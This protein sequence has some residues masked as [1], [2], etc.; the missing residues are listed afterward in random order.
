LEQLER[1]LPHR[2]G[3]VD[4]MRVAMRLRRKWKTLRPMQIFV[5]GKLAVEGNTGAFV[6]PAIEAG[7]LHARALLEF[8]GFQLVPRSSTELRNIT[9]RRRGDVYIGSFTTHSGPLPSVTKAELVARYPG[10]AGEREEAFATVLYIANKSLAHSTEDFLRSD[11]Q[12][13]AAYC[14]SGQLRGLLEQHFYARLNLE[15]PASPVGVRPRMPSSS[16]V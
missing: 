4:A 11:S 8:M 13:D 7:L 12:A 5:D 16:T 3:A 9:T 15:F 2:L 6:N 10:S 1:V 14:A